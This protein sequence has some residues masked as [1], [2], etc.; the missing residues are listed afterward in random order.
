MPSL[1]DN[2][3]QAR[4]PLYQ[5]WVVLGLRGTYGRNQSDVLSRIL[6]EWIQE[7]RE[8]L[9][10]QGLS[11]GDFRRPR[12]VGGQDNVDQKP[13]KKTDGFNK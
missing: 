6:G 9:A 4:V 10:D 8:W 7:H 3:I 13:R 5:K 1:D 12:R 2:Q 11:E